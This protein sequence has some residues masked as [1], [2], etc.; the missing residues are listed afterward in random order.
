MSEH[1]LILES[2]GYN[3]AATEVYRSVG[4]VDCCCGDPC[5]L[6][7]KDRATVLV[8]RLRYQ[9][10]VQFLTQFPN[11]R[12]IVSPT[13][14]LNH[15]DQSYCEKHNI[16]IVSLKGEARFLDT[17]RSTSELTFSLILALVRRIVP[18]AKSTVYQHRWDRD[19]FR[20]RELSSMTIGLVGLGR[21]GKHMAAHAK[22]FGMSVLAFDPYADQQGLAVLGVEFRTKAQLFSEADIISL[23]L[24][25]RAENEHFVTRE[26]F[27]R[28]KR[29]SYFINTARGELVCEDDIVWAL[30]EGVLAGAALDVL[31]NEQ[32]KKELFSKRIMEYAKRHDNVIITP[33][34]GGCTYEGMIRTELFA[35]QKLRD[36]ITRQRD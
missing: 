27:A 35:A 11:V 25:Y 1:I 23:H 10:D 33:H 6:N 30:E 7:G 36:M 8:C 32:D 26:D 4:T 22:A 17:I 29:G 16:H 24:D 21:I 2:G 19:A 14:G 3:P 20:G 15:I 31:S 12:F 9:L 18:A 13:T 34:I 5:E 28:M